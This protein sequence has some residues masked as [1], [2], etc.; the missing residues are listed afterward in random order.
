MLICLQVILFEREKAYLHALAITAGFRVP[1]V[2]PLIQGMDQFGCQFDVVAEHLLVLRD[3]VDIAD[4]PRQVTVY[5]GS[6]LTVP[7]LGHKNTHIHLI[8]VRSTA[9]AQLMT[10]GVQC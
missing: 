5:P 2:L 1:Q 8:P 10:P 9:R 6:E 3:S 4:A 7:Q